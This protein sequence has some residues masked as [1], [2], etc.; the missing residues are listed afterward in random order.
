MVKLGFI[1]EGDSEKILL[2]SEH[3]RNYL[4]THNIAFV[5]IIANAMGGGNLLPHRLPEY[6]QILKD[7]GATHFLIL[8]DLETDP[9]V[10]ETRNRIGHADDHTVI[11]CRKAIE[12][13][14][15]ADSSLLSKL[16]KRKYHFEHPETTTDMPFVTLKDEMRAHSINGPGLSKVKFAKRMINSGFS[17]VNAAKHDNCPS[18]KYFLT[19]LQEIAKQ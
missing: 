16:L 6:K 12:A 2:E 10:T 4:R 9:C 11:V 17:I 1:V 7:H 13:W 18:A 14:Y 15:L 19:K 3:F 8:T 5:E